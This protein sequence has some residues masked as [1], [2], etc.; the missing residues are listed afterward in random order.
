[1]IQIP[2]HLIFAQQII[3]TSNHCVTYLNVIQEMSSYSHGKLMRSVYDNDVSVC[4]VNF[5]FHL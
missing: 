1:M 2:H 4:A 3:V 5:I